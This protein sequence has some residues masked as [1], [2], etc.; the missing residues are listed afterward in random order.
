MRFSNCLLKS[1]HVPRSFEILSKSWFSGSNIETILFKHELRLTRFNDLCFSNC[2]RKSIYILRND[3]ILSNSVLPMD[4]TNRDHILHEVELRPKCNQMHSNW[5]HLKVNH[6]RCESRNKVHEFDLHSEKCQFCCSFTFMNCNW[7][8]I[9]F[10]RRIVSQIKT[11][12]GL[13]LE[14]PSFNNMIEETNLGNYIL[15]ILLTI[16]HMVSNRVS[17]RAKFC[18][19]WAEFHWKTISDRSISIEIYRCDRNFLKSGF[20]T[21]YLKGMTLSH[22]IVDFTKNID[23]NMLDFGRNILLSTYIQS[24]KMY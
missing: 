11:C 15:R 5:L 1:I 17:I 20:L 3:K 22:H 18:R 2:P 16:W 19:L 6:D 14:L 9:T 21:K 12:E 7:W 24:K 10:G 4:F 13:I 23:G 8:K